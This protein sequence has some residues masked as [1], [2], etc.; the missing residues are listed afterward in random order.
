MKKR[1]WLP[2]I[3]ATLAALAGVALITLRIAGG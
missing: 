2:L 1:N 3:V